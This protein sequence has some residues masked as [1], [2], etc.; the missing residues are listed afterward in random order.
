MTLSPRAELVFDDR[1]RLSP[2]LR[3]RGSACKRE[4][5]DR[6]KARLLPCRAGGY[7]SA[8]G[9]AYVGATAADKLGRI[10]FWR[11]FQTKTIVGFIGVLTIA[12]GAVAVEYVGYDRVLD[13]YT[14][15]R[16]AVS[17]WS[18]VES[19]DQ[20]STRFQFAIAKFVLT[21]A[22]D[23]AALARD[24]E[25]SLGAAVE[26]ALQTT[27]RGDRRADLKALS[28]QFG[29]MTVAFGG[30][31]ELTAKR[32]R[33]SK[34]DFA[35]LSAALRT[36]IEALAESA[37]LSD[38]SS[39][40]I[41]ARDALAKL[42][43]LSEKADRVLNRYDGALA[44]EVKASAGS[45]AASLRELTTTSNMVNRRLAAANE[46]SAAF[47]K[48]LETALAA[49][50][51]IDGLLIEVDGL[52]RQS[53]DSLRKLV[54]AVKADQERSEREM[55]ALIAR[56]KAVALAL[57]LGTVLV[58]VVL[59][60]ILGRG[61]TRPMVH[62]SAAMRQLASGAFDVVLP[63]LARQDEIGAMAAAVEQ[64]KETATARA[65]LEAS[66]RE[67]EREAVEVARRKQI[68]E[69]AA[70]F[71]ARV[72]G[73]VAHVS[74]SATQLQASASLLAQTAARTRELT[75]R[76]ANS[77][78]ETSADVGSV[79]SATEELSASVGEVERLVGRSR[80][81]AGTAVGQADVTNTRMQRLSDAAREV[82]EVV[83]LITSIAD[84]TNMLALNATIEAARAGDAGKG[85]SVVAA[86]VKTLASQTSQAT[87]RISA[88]ILVMQSATDESVDAIR[89]ISRTIEEIS[90]AAEAIISAV[91]QQN[92]VTQEI[93][94]N[95]QSVAGRTRD[96]TTDIL[97][98]DQ[99]TAET[100]QASGGVLAASEQLLVEC[101]RLTGELSAL[102]ATVGS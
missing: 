88:Q 40:Q 100:D 83:G 46:Q 55:T 38:I 24:A 76:V 15:Y 2:P 18:Q 86:E 78:Q 72:G 93:S 80:S 94:R 48:V 33:P 8:I 11:S 75:G 56:T 73:I 96:V 3:G 19:I 4:S 13:G 35:R 10:P 32:L 70:G 91:E 68:G 1:R 7:A 21:A 61:I 30:V 6:R 31:L 50:S 14:T 27:Q 41:G 64:F 101:D 54:E 22:D 82:G 53:A 42:A 74:S 89:E 52:I 25:S 97:Q 17:D 26:K 51:D 65:N 47:A 63:G 79:A 99:S 45:L 60:V 69:F 92:L 62:L 87:D 59:A 98:V 85:F 29:K 71:N 66:N 95:I 28:D 9:W 90:T 12:M 39:I 58:G 57:A 16:E 5:G 77:S 84:Q 34:D 81:I 43:V 37:T 102:M 23:D 44:S 20:A 67:Q 49:K 36:K